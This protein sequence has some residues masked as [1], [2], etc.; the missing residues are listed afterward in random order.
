MNCKILIVFFIVVFSSDVARTSS[1]QERAFTQALQDAAKAVQQ[2]SQLWGESNGS[3]RARALTNAAMA[4]NERMRIEEQH[5]AYQQQQYLRQQ[6]QNAYI[7]MLEEQQLKQL[8]K[9]QELYAKWER[10]RIARQEEEV[11][12]E[13]LKFL[14]KLNKN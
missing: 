3:Y 14:K 5:N 10:E 9:Q 6:E 2:T 1:P 7:K 8:E 13:K 11:R 12:K 4:A